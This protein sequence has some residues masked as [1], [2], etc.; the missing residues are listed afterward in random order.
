M[1]SQNDVAL[2]DLSNYLGSETNNA[3]RPLDANTG[4]HRFS[5]PRADGGKEAWLFLAA[6]FTIEALVWGKSPFFLHN[7]LF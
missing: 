4:R 6:G 7:P 5:L 2:N 3:A 1:E